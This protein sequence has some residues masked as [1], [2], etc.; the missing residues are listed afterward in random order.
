MARLAND[1]AQPNLGLRYLPGRTGLPRRAFLVA[2]SDIAAGAELVWDYGVHYPRSWRP[3]PSILVPPHESTITGRFDLRN[4]KSAPANGRKQAACSQTKQYARNAFLPSPRKS[5]PPLA[6]KEARKCAPHVTARKSAPIGARKSAPVTGYAHEDSEEED[7]DDEED[8][9]EG[10]D[11]VEMFA[12][13]SKLVCAP[14][15]FAAG[16]DVALPQPVIGVRG[17]DV[18]STSGLG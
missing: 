7:G 17:A 15:T 14:G 16:G 9:T 8:E 6:T 10:L 13:V 12:S 18:P 1:S 3:P 11:L 4:R 2:L 5:A